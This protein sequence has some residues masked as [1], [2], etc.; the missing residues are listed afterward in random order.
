MGA[1][2][3]LDRYD[4][5]MCICMCMFLCIE[6][7]CSRRANGNHKLVELVLSLSIVWFWQSVGLYGIYD[8][9]VRR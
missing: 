6:V 4:I 3:R 2:H 5:S 1:A 9:M 7:S 8:T